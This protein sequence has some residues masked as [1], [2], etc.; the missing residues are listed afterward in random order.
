MIRVN[1]ANIGPDGL[2]VSGEEDAAILELESTDA[3]PVKVLHD[4]R[5][6]LHASMVG[7]DLLVAGSAY[8]MIETI[9]ASCLK[10]IQFRIGAEKICIYHEKVAEEIV[11]IT[12]EIREEI[13]LALPSRFKCKEDCR[14]LCPGCGADLN[15]EKCSCKKKQKKITEEKQDHTW[16]ALDD[17]KF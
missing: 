5:Y 4:I 9:C 17:L 15:E 13:L 1:T 12:D 8:T 6:Q 16:D 10:E 7:A 14:G 2:E 3:I 11:D